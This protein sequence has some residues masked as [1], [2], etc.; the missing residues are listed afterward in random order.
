[1]D[2]YWQQIF[3]T[4]IISPELQKHVR[5]GTIKNAHG[6]NTVSL[7]DNGIANSQDLAGLVGS[8]FFIASGQ[9]FGTR[10]WRRSEM[11]LI[12]CFLYPFPPISYPSIS[13]RRGAI[14]LVKIHRICL[15]QSVEHMTVEQIMK[16]N[17]VGKY[18]DTLQECHSSSRLRSSS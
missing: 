13:S 8:S 1:M 7:R 12:L 5:S 10:L 15:Y 2:R 16:D 11:C 18:G 17:R 9:P 14:Q 4:F 3:I 6:G